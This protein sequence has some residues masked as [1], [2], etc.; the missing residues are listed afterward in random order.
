MPS[1]W[2]RKRGPFCFSF[3]QD[4]FKPLGDFLDRL[5]GVHESVVGG[6]VSP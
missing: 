2:T 3:P 4:L 1:G 6:K 5:F